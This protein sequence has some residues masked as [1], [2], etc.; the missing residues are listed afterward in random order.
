MLSCSQ[1]SAFATLQYPVSAA[2]CWTC[3]SSS[4]N[5]PRFAKVGLISCLLGVVA[6]LKTT[7]AHRHDPRL[8]VGEVHLITVAR[9]RFRWLWRAPSQLVPQLLFPLLTL[10]LLGVV[11]RFFQFISRLCTRLQFRF[12]RSDL[13]QV[14]LP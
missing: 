7:A 9:P 5:V 12:R 11:G 4:G 8:G 3:P 2:K 10:R 14:R 6:L 13:L 1:A